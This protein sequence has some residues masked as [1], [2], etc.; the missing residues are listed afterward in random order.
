[1]NNEQDPRLELDPDAEA[2]VTDALDYLGT[3]EPPAEFVGQ[4]MW[5]TRH[6]ALK[7]NSQRRA[8]RQV[9]EAT[10]MAKKVLIGV[11]GIAA[12]GLLVAYIFGFPPASHTEGTIGAAQRYQAEQIKSSDV[13]VTNPELQAF[14]QTDVFDK[15]IHDKQAMAALANPEMAAAL[16]A[17]RSLRPLRT[18]S[19]SW[20]SRPR[21]FGWRSATHRSYRRWRRRSSDSPSRT[22]SSRQR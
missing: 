18:R 4:V 12:A 9:G 15:L 13:K 11:I 19:S 21:R 7:Q 3:V 8:T 20:R 16:P 22:R 17:R 2:R 5:R 6:Q 1:M 10:D 14:I